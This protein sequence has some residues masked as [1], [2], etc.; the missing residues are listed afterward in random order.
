[1]PTMEALGDRNEFFFNVA[2]GVPGVLEGHDADIIA[3]EFDPI[4]DPTRWGD[5]A[6]VTH[7][8][9]VGK[10]VKFPS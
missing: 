9:K 6:R 4:N 8:W 1:M 5:P 2:D 10:P 7:V 3:L